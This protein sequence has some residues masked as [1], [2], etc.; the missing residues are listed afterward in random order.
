MTEENMVKQLER[1]RKAY[2][3]TVEQYNKGFDSF[4]N[5]PKNF[6]NTPDFKAFLEGT[7]PLLTGSGV[8]EYKEYLA[9]KSG[10]RFL[11]AGCCANLANYRLDK[12]GSTYYGVD[13]APALINAMKGFVKHNQI[14]IGG[15]YVAEITRLPFD[16]CF[17]DVA[18]VIGVLEYC[19]FGY[20]KAALS[21]LNRVLKIQ[22]KMVLDIPNLEHPHVNTMF[23]LEE[24]LARPNIP[25]SRS[26]FEKIL[27]SLFSVERVDD[28]RIM[29]KYFVRTM[30]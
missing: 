14:S 30:K 23:K 10:M 11:D 4:T 3:L 6:K 29:L 24:Y 5:V 8:P 17:F 15:L 28:S 1:I 13:I 26:A 18:A 9:P 2:N 27:A 19:S 25:K 21:E 12:W 20:T 7:G 22:S 16:D